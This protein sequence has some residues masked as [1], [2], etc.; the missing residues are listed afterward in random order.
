MNKK[1]RILLVSSAFSPEISPRS[2][3]AT[4]LAKE[5]VRQGNE[6]TVISKF[7]DNDYSDL[8][9]KFPITLKMWNKPSYPRIPEFKKSP[10][11]YF[12]RAL[13]RILAVF[14]EYPAIEEMFSVRK[15]LKHESGYEL[16][17]SFAVPHPVHWGVALFRS[18]K[19]RVAETWVADCGDPYM[20]A[21]LDTFRK[22]FYFR[23]PEKHFCRKCDF[24][25]IPFKEMQT[26]FY[27][28][29]R[30]KISVIPQGFNLDEIHLYEGPFD[31]TI[32]VFIF[33]GSIIPGK[34]DLGLFLDFLAD[35]EYDFLFVIYTNQTE[36]F[37][38]YK[39]KLGK[40]LILRKYIERISLIYELSK[41][42][43]LVNVDTIHDDCKNIEAV[44][45][46]L[47]D[48]SLAD[49]PI[50]NLNSA[51]LDTEIVLQFL[52]KDYSKQRVVDKSN[53]DITKVSAK[54]IEL[55]K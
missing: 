52:N 12:L 26:Q 51:Y 47:I 13:S 4:E 18:A 34:R 35:Q 54:F 2:F 36:L 24:I 15:M 30:S 10:I 14:F 53:Y 5:F 20:F 40:R 17:I 23:F 49:R 38:K 44:P 41:A 29:F 55:I 6:V 27:P 3:R 46:K 37:D 21:R 39:T 43:F 32:P 48:Y 9:K 7:R 22:P 8:L 31:N 42:D 25:S 28:E 16:M 45:S 19:N 11:S 33:A 50:L 1:K